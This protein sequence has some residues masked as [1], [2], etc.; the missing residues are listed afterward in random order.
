M[1]STLVINS[2]L[3]QKTEEVN[4]RNWLRTSSN[5]EK[6]ALVIGNSKYQHGGRLKEPAKDADVMAAA[7]QVQGYDVVLGY[8]LNRDELYSITDEFVAKLSDYKEAVIYY[9]GHGFQVNGKNYIV[10]TDANP[11]GAFQVDRHCMEV[12][13]FLQAI[14]K[15]KIPKLILIDAC[16]DNPFANE[17]SDSEMR[18]MTAGMKA[19]KALRNSLIV[20]STAENTK[21]SDYNQFAE[22]MAAAIEEGGCINSML[23]EVN[24]K[25]QALD[26]H[27]LIRPNGLLYPE[28]CFGEK[29]VVSPVISNDSDGDLIP[30]EIDKC[31]DAFGNIENDG[32]PEPEI[33]TDGD[34][35][36]DKEDKCPREKGIERL[37]GCPE[38]D[39]DTDEDGLL[40]KED[41]CPNEK[42]PKTN[43][44]C[45]VNLDNV[46]TDSRDGQTYRWKRMK[47]GKKWM[48]ENLNFKT[49]N[50]LA[51]NQDEK[52]SEGY[53]RLYLWKEALD[54]CPKGWWLP[55]DDEWWTFVSHYGKAYSL[56][57]EKP[58]NSGSDAGEDAFINLTK[59]GHSS[60]EG[61]LSG[62]RKSGISTKPGKFGCYW[63]S[64]G[65]SSTHAW[66]Y[67][68]DQ[69]K[70]KLLRYYNNKKA[71]FSCRCIQD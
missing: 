39:V 4:Y 60:F 43:N 34:G 5:N 40:D 38:V 23:G 59:Y 15:P 6:L 25:I 61:R 63:T 70:K 65:K 56:Y 62:Y 27:Q 53:G 18:D 46:F 24:V 48:V 19:V 54:I 2:L 35:V 37:D 66:Y 51:V 50:S 58:E 9:A 12:N 57:K 67:Y 44:G 41:D 16:R 13:D 28:I 30:D 7:L 22:L 55:N 26:E 33:D 10:P 31:P 21:V 17:W 29:P 32:C 1:L 47:D 69:R 49:R 14:N 8:N 36:I 11:Q 42:G 20:F 71:A 45:P 68:F 64:S 3:A 52:N